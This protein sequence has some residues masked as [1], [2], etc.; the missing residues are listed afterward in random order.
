MTRRL[1]LVAALAAVLLGAPASTAQA[2]PAVVG[3]PSSIAA[4][5]DSITRAFDSGFP[6]VDVPAN[7]WSTGTNPAVTSHYARLVA[8]NAA[9]AGHAYNNARTG[10]RMAALQG[11]LAVASAQGADYVTV[12]IGA[13]DACR[14]SEAAMTSV[15]DFRA[16]F[17]AALASF[18]AARPDARIYVVSI[19]DIH[20]LWELLHGHVIAPHVWTAFGICQSLLARPASMAPADVDRRRRVRDRVIAYNAQLAGVCAV[21]VHCRFDGN[22][23]FT[24]S[25]TEA[26]V[27]ALDFFHPSVAGQRKLAA[28]SWGAGFDFSDSVAPSSTASTTPLGARV[29]RVTLAATDDAGVSGIEYRLGGGVYRRYTR[30]LLLFRGQTLAYRAVDVNGNVE[31]TRTISLPVSS[32]A[33]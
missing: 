6:L 22:A 29:V 14:S 9:I 26:D 21:F 12:L 15:A 25:F 5:G 32:L 10:A 4:A 28:V 24:T 1:L 31:A 33:A 19:P 18:A 2:S 13:N 7:S 17:A 20:R 8:G 16:Q 3:Y 11:Q 30:P 23:A 27:S